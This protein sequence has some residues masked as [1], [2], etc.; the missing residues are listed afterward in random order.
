[1]AGIP[2]R[3]STSLQQRSRFRNR[4]PEPPAHRSHQEGIRPF[5]CPTTPTR[6]CPFIQRQY[7]PNK[8]RPSRS[9]RPQFLQQRV[10]FQGV[11]NDLEKTILTSFAEGGSHT[12]GNH[13]SATL[14]SGSEPSEEEGLEGSDI[15]GRKKN[16]T[17]S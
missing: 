15:S 16:D 10:P 17:S 5:Q 13:G 6:G 7:H 8:V 2:P 1:M 11:T 4:P 12:S 3:E 9:S 14:S